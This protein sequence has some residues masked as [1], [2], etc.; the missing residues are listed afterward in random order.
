MQQNGTSILELVYT[1]YRWFNTSFFLTFFS[2]FQKF[3]YP[4]MN[5]N[6]FSKKADIIQ[7]FVLGGA[8]LCWTLGT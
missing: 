7:L 4:K 6:R 1:K 3:S 2:H 8:C 5:S